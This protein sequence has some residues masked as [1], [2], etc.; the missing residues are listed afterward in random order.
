MRVFRFLGWVALAGGL[1][2]GGC[3]HAF[4]QPEVT[5]TGL[6]LAGI[7]LKGG[8]VYADVAVRNPNHYALEADRINY[9]L[10]VQD[11]SNP[12]NWL[13]F[14]A[15]RFEQDVRIGS[16]KTTEIQ[17]PIQFSFGT[18]S[19][20]VQSI[21]TNGIFNYQV[22]GDIHVKEPITRTVPY[23]HQGVVTMAGAH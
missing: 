1:V 2:L 3:A 12:N 11:P 10:R 14:T 6:Q 15:G 5:L 19:A 23:R 22:V 21:M 4:R 8:L 18:A 9:D 7:G 17:V 13:P 20:A 16:G